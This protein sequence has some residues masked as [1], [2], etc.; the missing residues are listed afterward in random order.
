MRYITFSLLIVL[1]LAGCGFAASTSRSV[2]IEAQPDVA[3]AAQTAQPA[4][5]QTPEQ[6]AERVSQSPTAPAVAQAATSQPEP[7]SAP[8]ATPEPPARVRYSFPMALPGRPP[9]DG[10]FVRH[11]AYSEN[12]WF[13][14]NHW[15]TGEDWYLIEGNIAGQPVYAVADGVVW[16]V[17]SNYPG[18]VVIIQHPDGL[19]SM[20]GHLDPAV[21]VQAGQ[22]VQRGDLLG[23]ILRR[24][25]NVPAHLH[26]EIR[27]F[28]LADAINGASPRYGFPCGVNCPPG[29]GYWPIAAPD[30]PS[31]LGWR[32]PTHVI[33]NRMGEAV[34]EVVV[35]SSP[36]STEGISLWSAPP[37]AEEPRVLAPI[38]WQPG[39]PFALLGTWTGAENTRETSAR[40]YEVWYNI[41]LSDGREGWVTAVEPSS[42][43]TGSNGAPATVYFNLLPVVSPPNSR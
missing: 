6:V 35:P 8:T 11:T 28:Y 33:V 9:G 1:F 4:P 3:Q 23:T 14:P 7:T 20:Y 34:R 42:F 32:V 17:G 40:S 18:R 39:Q 37:V 16:Y 24:S 21:S 2:P 43:E 25:D 27:T 22:R 41:R 38:S 29:P 13:N 10:F 26:F 30:H 15:H 36:A 19:F 5:S 31:D 12:T